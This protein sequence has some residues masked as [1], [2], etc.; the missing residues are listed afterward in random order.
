MKDW[1]WLGCVSTLLLFGCAEDRLVG[2]PGLQI[3]NGSQFPAPDGSRTSL[4]QRRAYIVAPSDRLTVDV[5]GVA[6]LTR[7]IQVDPNGMF[8]LPLVGALQ[9]A[10]KTPAELAGTIADRLRGRYMRD[11]QVAVNAETVNQ[12]ITVE[13]EVRIP[14]IYPVTSRTT[15]LQA[16]ARAQGLTD[17]ANTEYVVVFRQVSDRKM[18][19][20]YDVRAIRQGMYEDPEVYGNDVISVGESRARRIFTV[21]FQTAALLTGPI[22]AILN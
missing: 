12:N 21:A 17:N 9:A 19:A 5:F 3:V 16:L 6:E 11:P 4:E 1:L 20:L 14:G 7:T 22:I 18:A 13:G 10:G 2:R 15:L 8:T